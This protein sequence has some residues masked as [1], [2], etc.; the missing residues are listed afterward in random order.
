MP[1]I[2]VAAL[3]LI[4]AFVTYIGVSIM[5]QDIQVFDSSSPSD[6]GIPELF[7]IIIG[8]L[9]SLIGGICTIFLLITWA[10]GA[11]IQ[12]FAKLIQLFGAKRVFITLGVVSILLCVYFFSGLFEKPIYVGAL[13]GS[14][15]SKP[16][17]T[18]SKD[19]ILTTTDAKLKIIHATDSISK[20]HPWFLVSYGKSLKGYIWGGNLCAKEYWINGLSGRCESHK[21]NLLKNEF[22]LNKLKKNQNTVDVIELLYAKLPGIWFSDYSGNYKFTSQMEI[23]IKG[24]VIGWWSIKHEENLMGYPKFYLLLDYFPDI[25]K[26]HKRFL[27]T[28]L[29]NKTLSLKGK[30]FFS[31]ERHFT[32]D[33]PMN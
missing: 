32:K 16:L 9:I 19:T 6:G 25:N 30:G 22:D 3:F 5:S 12:L 4:G 7:N 20:G 10:F 13:D 15:Y 21:Q 18:A 1:H 17:F 2:I 11:L 24:K 26:S 29:N 8:G 33:N 28:R 14:I 31:Q 27:I 23:T